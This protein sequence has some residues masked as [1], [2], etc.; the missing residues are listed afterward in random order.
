MSPI[1]RKIDCLLLKVS[2]LEEGLK[3]YS[4]KLGHEVIW[5][6]PNAAGLRLPDT[7]AELVISTENGP[8]TDLK[9]E[10]TRNA[11]S[12]LIEAGAKSIAAPFEIAI[13]LC[14]VLEDPWG[15]VITILDTSKGLLKVDEQ[16][17]VVNNATEEEVK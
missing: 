7:D 17:N 12:A 6:T 2:N 14:A 11:Y 10:D 9:V 5:K 1:F 4:E 16:K 13:G 8:E 3:F 15:N